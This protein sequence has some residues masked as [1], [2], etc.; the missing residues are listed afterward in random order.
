[1][2]LKKKQWKKKQIKIINFSSLLLGGLFVCF[3]N[4]LQEFIEQEKKFL[5]SVVQEY[6]DRMFE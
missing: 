2:K 3:F 1:M 6:Q 4:Y 5:R